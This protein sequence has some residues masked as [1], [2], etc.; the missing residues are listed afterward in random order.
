MK[1]RDLY[2][3]ETMSLM[4]LRNLRPSSKKVRQQGKR[5][6]KTLLPQECGFCAAFRLLVRPLPIGCPVRGGRFQADY[7]I[8]I[9]PFWAKNQAIPEKKPE[10]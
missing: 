5:E 8:Y 2:P 9:I 10:K 1:S 6:G 7:L 3:S 4:S